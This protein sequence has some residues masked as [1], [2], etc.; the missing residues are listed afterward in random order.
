MFESFVDIGEGELQ[1]MDVLKGFASFLVVAFGGTIIGVIFG[2]LTSFMTTVTSQAPLLE[3][4]FVF[5]MAYLSY[6][7]AEIF[8]LSGIMA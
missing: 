6:L 3:P 4:L 5:S 7:S 2:Y 8:H 1:A